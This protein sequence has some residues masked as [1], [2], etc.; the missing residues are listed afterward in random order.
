VVEA[1]AEAVTGAMSSATT[2]SVSFGSHS[3]IIVDRLF[4]FYYRSYKC[5]KNCFSSNA[6]YFHRSIGKKNKKK[7]MF[8]SL[9]PACSIV[10]SYLAGDYFTR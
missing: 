2:G 9:T 1:A 7:T 3:D 10:A 5:L 8:I 6:T 4:I